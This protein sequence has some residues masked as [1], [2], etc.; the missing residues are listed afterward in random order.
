MLCPSETTKKS[1]KSFFYVGNGDKNL[2]G[3]NTLDAINI[4]RAEKIDPTSALLSWKISK[5]FNPSGGLSTSGM[6]WSI[7][8]RKV[9]EKMN[10]FHETA[11]SK[12]ASSPQVMD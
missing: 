3:P 12:S 7:V 9:G 11:L 2:F 6:D 8:Y 5:P 10:V 4:L 1:T